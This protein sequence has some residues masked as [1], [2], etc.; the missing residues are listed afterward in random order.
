MLTSYL[1]GFIF[2]IEL[3][4]V[5]ATYIL[6]YLSKAMPLGPLNLA[7]A[8]I[9]FATPESPDKDPAIVVTTPV[10]LIIRMA[11]FPVSAT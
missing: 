1:S 5:S 8:P 9:P 4:P 7:A 6:P 11:L 3:F 10:T 2:R